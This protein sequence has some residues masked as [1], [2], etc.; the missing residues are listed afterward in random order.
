[1]S[2]VHTPL[3][4]SLSAE[5]RVSTGYA[6]W[7]V[8]RKSGSATRTLALVIPTCF[9]TF[10]LPTPCPSA[11]TL[12]A[13]RDYS[14]TMP[15]GLFTIGRLGNHVRNRGR[16]GIRASAERTQTECQPWTCLACGVELLALAPVLVVLTQRKSTFLCTMYVVLRSMTLPRLSFVHDQNRRSVVDEFFDTERT[17]AIVIATL[18]ALAFALRFYKINHPEQVV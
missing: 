15:L 12:S 5:R 1:M 7:G 14:Y 2:F 13:V 16:R 4:L 11:I 18:T 3:Y 8:N 6:S 9:I 10:I 17:S